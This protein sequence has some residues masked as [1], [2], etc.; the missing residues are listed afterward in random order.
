MSA[1]NATTLEDAVLSVGKEVTDLTLMV[2]TKSIPEGS[3]E[4]ELRAR[5]EDRKKALQDLNEA[6]ALISVAPKVPAVTAEVSSEDTRI[7]PNLPF[8]QWFN[9]VRDSNK[10]VFRDNIAHAIHRFEIVLKSVDMDYDRHWKR[11]LPLCLPLN[12]CDWMD[13]FCEENS[14]SAVPWKTVKHALMV[15][16]G[17]EATLFARLR[18]FLNCTREKDEPVRMFID[19]FKELRTRAEVIN[20][21]IAALVFM[22]SLSPEDVHFLIRTFGLKEGSSNNAASNGLPLSLGATCYSML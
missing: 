6:V 1:V 13:K 21:H 22:D 4:E 10:F 12:M 8:F 2:T 16:Y 9:F 18:N 15:C 17:V 7:P 3:S 11:L 5:L 20:K 19:R 14:T